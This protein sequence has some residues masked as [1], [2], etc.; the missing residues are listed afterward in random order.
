MKSNISIVAIV[1]LLSTSSTYAG[2]YV[3]S[4]VDLSYPTVG[5]QGDRIS[6][7]GVHQAW[8]AFDLS[9]IPDA[10]SVILASF[11]ADMLD[12]NG[13]ES[14]RTLWYDS[15]DS[16]IGT[17]PTQKLLSDPGNASADNIVGTLLHSS[18]AYVPETIVITHN[19]ANDLADNYITLMLTGPQGGGFADGAVWLTSAELTL[20][21]IPA[22]GA[23]FIAGFG[24]GIV[25]W[26]RRRKTL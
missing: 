7:I 8:F 17:T 1:I 22:P 14:Q 20:E 18:E 15:D 13:S 2:L 3:L 6:Q 16:W 19:W 23:I 25:G 4:P 5:D 11:T 10:E 12:F 21:T 24:V 26:L 9:S